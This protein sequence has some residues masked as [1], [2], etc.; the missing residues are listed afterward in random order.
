MNSKKIIAIFLAVCFLMVAGVATVLITINANLPQII[1]LK[2]YDPLL[3]T[4]VYDR[5]GQKIGEFYR[6]RRILIPEEEMPDLVKKA[7]IA[8]E[9][10][11]FYE[12]GGVNYIAILR[13]IIANIRAGRKVQGAST[14][15]QQVARSLLLTRKKTYTRKIKEILLSYKMEENL[16]KD[17]I[18][19]LY[20]NQ[21]YL[22]QGAYGIGAA[23]K[24]Y[25]RKDVKDLTVSE[26]A[27][28]A[29]LPKAPSR[30][31]PL[32]NPKRA[33]A[34]Q[35]YV[36]KRMAEEGFITEEEAQKAAE[37]PLRF[38]V[39]Q[40]YNEQ[41]PYYLETLRQIL[42]DRLG[43]E[44]VFNKG[45]RVYTGLDLEKQKAAQEELR[46][47]LRNLDK[48]QGY[49]GPLG[50]LEDPEQVAQFLLKERNDLMDKVSP[51][52]V[53]KPD[54]TLKE[55]GP[56]NLTGFYP[57]KEGET[58]EPQ[59]LPNIPEY[60]KPDQVV[61]GIVM[62]VDDKWGLVTVRFA[63]SKGLI[64]VESMSWARKPDP[65]VN[66]RWA[67]K[68]E[69][70]SE[71][72]KKGDII[73]VRVVGEKFRSRRIAEK[74]RDLEEK[75]RKQKKEYERP[76]D[77]PPFEDYALLELEQDPEVEGALL[78]FDEKTQDVVALV[79]GYD[80]KKS[81]FNR[82]LQALR[83]TGSTFKAFVY[84]SALDK[85][86][87][88]ATVLL[89]SPVVYEEEKEGQ[90]EDGTEEKVVTKWKPT[91]FS[92]KFMGEILFRNALIRSLNV[93]TVKIIEKIGV[94]WV[95]DYA[96]RL[97]IFSKLNMDYTMALGSSSVTL[98][99]MTKAFANLGRLGKRIYPKL[100]HR[101]ENKDGEV[102]LEDVSLDVK[103]E[104]KI[105]PIDEEF[106][107]RRQAYL[108]YKKE[109]ELSK[110]SVKEP[111]GASVEDEES[112]SDEVSEEEA[113]RRAKLAKEPP[114]FFEDPD[115]LIDPKTAYIAT[116]MLKGVIEGRH[117]TSRAAR[118]LGRPAAGKTGTTNG[119]FDAWFMGYTPQIVTGVWVGFDDERSLGRGEVGGR[120][121]L[122]IWLEYMK[123]A[124]KGLPVKDFPVVDGIVFANIDNETGKLASANSKEVVRQA[125]LEGTEPKEISGQAPTSDDDKDF[126]KEDLS[127]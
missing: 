50:H 124:H 86:Y 116:S 14:I 77:L 104:D 33:K 64:D 69:K 98:Y 91:N 74:L 84:T 36:L 79:G 30:F 113:K 87:T 1:T 51:V 21:I 26:V 82:A 78:S 45:L 71:V 126:F 55:K 114:I 58:G 28:L 57:Q 97:G 48:R 60:I 111:P 20:L 2:D 34:R 72:L 39:K 27:L 9:D 81:K 49:R 117:G 112:L 115:Q 67:P 59:K 43:S 108:E 15:T 31:S 3:A 44:S 35:R 17:D 37:E 4:E 122:P 102:L 118:A 32:V 42:V 41:A 103:F 121:A 96:R 105:K 6:E 11:S 38:Y 19:Y 109:L 18:L 85:G 120:A 22:G 40:D 23:A 125:F 24:I 10:S 100:I 68:I 95:A 76:E 70:P 94:E 127:E 46:R 93:P 110:N 63:E 62:N 53:L 56:L 106:E 61:K 73:L 83:Q 123:K 8:A 52:R 75:L 88:P 107:Q 101:V 5:H 47:G 16:T 13:A 119:Y 89:D 92:K 29:G 7:F 90:L 54:G 80:F 65:S 12:H 25:F 99:E 66:F